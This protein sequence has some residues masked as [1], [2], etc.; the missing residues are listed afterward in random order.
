M[1]L[2]KDTGNQRYYELPFKIK[3]HFGVG[4]EKTIFEMWNDDP[5]KLNPEYELA[6]DISE[7]INKICISVAHTHIERLVFPAF[8]ARNKKTGEIHLC[9]RNNTIDGKLTFMIY[10]GSNNAVYPD[11]VYIRHLRL[12]NQK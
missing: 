3:K 12:N 4:K 10:G 7:S 2:V 9:H 5:I 1:K 11:G 8:N 6:E